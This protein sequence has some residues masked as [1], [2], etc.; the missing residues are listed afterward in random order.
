MATPEKA[1]IELHRRDIDQFESFREI[2]VGYA[3]ARNGTPY[4]CVLF[5]RPLDL[6][7]QARPE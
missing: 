1:A 3:V 6:V 2:G 7:I 4:W 5:A